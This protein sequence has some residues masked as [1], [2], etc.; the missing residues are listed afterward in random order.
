MAASIESTGIVSG[1]RP[2]SPA[3]SLSELIS[4]VPGTRSAPRQQVC[5]VC[6]G[7]LLGEVVFATLSAM[8]Q[9]VES[10]AVDHRRPVPAAA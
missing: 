10:P 5:W 1:I 6:P 7:R 8:T 9:T 3:G 4:L 2:F